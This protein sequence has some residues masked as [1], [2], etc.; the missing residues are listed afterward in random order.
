VT[1]NIY[2]GQFR[3][4][5]SQTTMIPTKTYQAK[6][7]L[8]NHRIITPTPLPRPLQPPALEDPK[9][10]ADRIKEKLSEALWQGF[11]SCRDCDRMTERQEGENGQPAHCSICG[12][13]R[14]DWN[15]PVHEAI[16]QE[17][18]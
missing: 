7:P 8:R 13:Y 14:I 4:R 15:P 17:V 5:Q 9:S 6:L 3:P 11:W 2:R 18:A 1:F 10:L 12:S 16:R